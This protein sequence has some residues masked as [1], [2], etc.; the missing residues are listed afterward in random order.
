MGFVEVFTASQKGYK[1]DFEK[2]LDIF[3]KATG[4]NSGDVNTAITSPRRIQYV[5]ETLRSMET[6]DLKIRVRS[7]E[8]EKALERMALTNTRTENLVIASVM[9]NVAGIAARPLLSYAGVLGAGFFLFQ[10]FIGN[11]II[12]KFDKTQLKF[13]NNKFEGEEDEQ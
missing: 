11:T 4:L 1:S 3:K 5:E 8:N 7:L 10:A 2:N 12:K 9:L 13:V 6:G